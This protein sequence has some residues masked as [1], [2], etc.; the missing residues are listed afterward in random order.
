MVQ[1]G[2]LMEPTPFCNGTFRGGEKEH[3][4]EAEHP[5]L[6][7]EDGRQRQ[8]RWLKRG[9][10]DAR[11]AN[12]CYAGA[13]LGL[14]G[15]GYVDRASE[16]LAAASAVRVGRRADRGRGGASRREQRGGRRRRNR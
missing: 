6:G 8:R 10:D 7:N 4:H 13:D 2:L 9:R 16:K 15:A 1:P 5:D 3:Y 11:D 12:R 14:H